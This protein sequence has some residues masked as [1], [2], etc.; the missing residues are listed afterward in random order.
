MDLPFHGFWQGH[1]LTVAGTLLA[2]VAPLKDE[3]ELVQL[4]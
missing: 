2:P 1:L 3:L 4:P